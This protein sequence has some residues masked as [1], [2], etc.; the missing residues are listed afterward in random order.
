MITLGDQLGHSNPLYSIVDIL[1]ARGGVRTITTFSDT[2]LNTEFSTIPDK[3][4]KNVSLLIVQDTNSLYY[5]SGLTA[6]NTNSWTI[7]TTGG[8]GG[9]GVQGPQGFE[10]LQGFQGF[11]G[12][13][14]LLGTQGFQGFQGLEGLLGTQGF[15]GLQGLAGN[16]G[17]DGTQ[18][19]QGPEGL[20][21]IDGVQ[22][23]QGLQG[24]DGVQG[25]QGLQGIDGVQGPQGLQ[26]FEGI[27]G[28]NSS[29]WILSGVGS[30]DPGS[31]FFSVDDTTL[32][33]VTIINIDS[34]NYL[35]VDFSLW[36][37]ELQTVTSI[38][39]SGYLQITEFDNASISSIYSVNPGNV[40]WNAGYTTIQVSH[41]SGL[42]SLTSGKSYSI[43]WVYSGIK[44][45]QGFQGFQGLEGLQG[46]QGFQGLEGL[47]GVQ[48][49]EGPQ[50]SQG[51]LGP[52]GETGIGIPSGG[53]SGQALVKNSDSDY[54][55]VW[56]TISSGPGGGGILQYDNKTLFPGTGSTSTLYVAK[57]TNEGWYWTGTAYKALSQ[58]DADLVVSLSGGKTFGKYTT[59]QTIPSTGKTPRDVI[60]M[61]IVEAIIPTVNLSSPTSIPFN[62]TNISNVLNF[63]YTINSLGASAATAVLEW[64]R[65]GT[66]SWTTLSTSTTP[67]SYTHTLTDT[68]YNSQSFN[69]RYTV[70]DTAGASQTATLNIT[71]IAYSAPSIS[72]S[73][74]GNSL[75]TGESNTNRELGNVSTTLSGSIS[76]VPLSSN[77][78][79]L[80]SYTLEFSN[81]GGS[82]WNNVP[83]AVDIAISG[84]S[85]T[86]STIVHNDPSL[87]SSTSIRYRAKVKDTYRVY[88]SSQDYSA[89]TLVT[90]S[91]FVWYGPLSTEPTNSAAVRAM[92]SRTLINTLSNPFNL[93]TGN[94][95]KIFTVAIPAT[96]TVTGVSDLDA[97]GASIPI[98]NTYPGPAGQYVRN[99]FN[100]NDFAGNAVSYKVYTC[101]NAAPYSTSHRHQITRS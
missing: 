63:S 42:G 41:I 31:T 49:A 46:F 7:I 92:G 66:G 2:A 25:P 86:I 75:G 4:K 95:L 51:I 67:G 65:N 8:G 39:S 90:Y 62:T 73:V 69:Y 34:Q 68:I 3:I 72:L 1:D 85:A 22:G 32:S 83:G 54:D 64:R 97:L 33:N 47:Q 30:G 24:I 14:G 80:V 18:G 101:Q 100:V 91:N 77:I 87:V 93:I 84:Q 6:T 96:S 26:G 60:Q 99:I 10:G 5:L 52:Q 21:G 15:Q 50:G 11:Q 12:L 20:Q 38:G 9:G 61:A 56:T 35:S 23:P 58:Y 27:D 16:Q 29:R 74:V 44:G 71:P 28:A 17:L 88:T 82:I 19:F 45:S 59:G 76:R 79:D 98:N 37:K 36:L 55:T 78:V 48:G 89:V 81:D 40:S 57:D 43:S 94:T 53:L 70:T 13:E